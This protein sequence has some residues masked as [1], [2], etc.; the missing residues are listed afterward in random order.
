MRKIF[1]SALLAVL[2]LASVPIETAAFSDD[3]A[4]TAFEAFLAT[5]W[6]EEKQYFY[7][8]SDHQ[9][10]SEHAVG[11]EGGLYTDYWWEA[12]LWEMVMDVYETTGSTKA[13]A[14]IGQIYD[15][16]NAA[17]P[18]WTQNDW[19]DDMGWW[20]RGSIRAYELTGDER[21]LQRAK[22]IFDYIWQYEDDTYGG[23]I[24]WKNVDVGNGELNEKNVATNATATY[25]AMRIYAI[26]GD[27]SYYD[28]A[29]ELFSWLQVR[30]YNGGHINDHIA[31]DDVVYSWDWT[32]NFGNYAGAALEFYLADGEQTYLD[33]ATAA[34]QW[35]TD[36]MTLSGTYLF[37]GHDDTGGFKAILTRNMKALADKAGQTQYL[38]IIQVNATQAW[39]HVN[40]AKIGAYDWTLPTPELGSGDAAVQSLSAAATVAVLHQAAADGYTGVVEG[41]RVY[42]A[43]NATRNDVSSE[44]NPNGYSGRGYVAGWINE[45]SSVVFNANIIAAGTYTLQIRYAAGAGDAVRSLVINGETVA[46]PAFSGTADWDAWATAEIVVELEN[47]Y[48]SIELL[49]ESDAGSNNYLNLDYVQLP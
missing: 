45:G 11:P 23:G 1:I 17:Y 49:F 14:M 7:T 35:V 13:L 38:P 25:T 5:Y 4:A 41:N 27:R 21:Y 46:T 48:N 16:F 37:E 18:D 33:Q 36:N 34:I 43:E 30:F 9:V 42:E 6:D 31:G 47:G 26:T 32:Y 24:W 29:A 44:A 19:N 12:Q 28:K 8:Y 15:G 3:E 39:N 2:L 10:H 20:A 40:S 22:D